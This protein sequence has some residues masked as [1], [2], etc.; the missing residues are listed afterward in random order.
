MITGLASVSR[1]C[2]VPFRIWRRH[3]RLVGVVLIAFL[4]VLVDAGVEAQEST[5]QLAAI[6]LTP[7]RRQ[8]IGL[9]IATVEDKELVGRIE[10]TGQVEPDEQL[11]GYVQTRFSG[12]IRPTLA[13]HHADADRR[14]RGQPVHFR[15]RR[16]R[17]RVTGAI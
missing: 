14:F 17:R 11:E 7:E 12:W 1:A 5:S 15:S 8:L 6:Q 9:Q 13:G 2:A 10:T 3:V 16:I 4:I